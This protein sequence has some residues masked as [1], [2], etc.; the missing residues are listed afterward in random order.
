M[1]FTLTLKGH[2]ASIA[3]DG[4][5]TAHQSAVGHP[6]CLKEPGYLLCNRSEEK[7]NE[8]EAQNAC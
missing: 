5:D 6:L 2:E 3:I 1:R 8:K 4:I 7:K